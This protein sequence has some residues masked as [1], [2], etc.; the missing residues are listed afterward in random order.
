MVKYIYLD[1][2]AAT[3]VDPVV[4]KILQKEIKG[5]FGNPSSS[6]SVGQKAKAKLILCRKKISEAINCSP[7]EIVFTGSGTESINLA[8]K[9]FALKNKHKGNHIITTN[10]EHSSVLESVRWLEKQGFRVTYLKVDS[11]GLV[12]LEDLKEAIEEE[13]IL[14]SIMYANNEIGTIQPIKEIAQICKS[15]EVAFHT[16]T[17]QATCSLDIDVESLGI[18]MMSL[19]GSKIYGPKGVGLL[20]KR[21]NIEIEPLIHGGSQEWGLRSGTEN[22]ALIMGFTEAIILS[23]TRKSADNK[24]LLKMRDYLIKRISKEIKDSKLNGD[25]TKR[26]N[27]NVNFTFEGVEAEVLMAKLDMEGIGVSAGSA[28]ASG[29]V[30]PS[31]VILALGVPYSKAHGTIRISVGRQNTQK[32]VVLFID[33]LKIAIEEIRAQSPL[34]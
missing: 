19:N 8:I 28:C 26:L 20:Y 27:N 21:S 18:D 12:N 30:E 1:N 11:R 31:H 29:S 7:R 4:F 25:G 22:V 17:C 2:A 15:K 24:K 16:D 6:H 5:T 33:K 13:T 3:P 23:Q 14:V 34:Y 9:G 10:I 32:E